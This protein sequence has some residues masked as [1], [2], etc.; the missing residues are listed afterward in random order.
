VS[1][2][3][4]N[5]NPLDIF[6]ASF[7]AMNDKLGR[8]EETQAECEQIVTLLGLA[9]GAKI[10]DAGCGFGRTVGAF[11]QLGFDATGVDISP[12]VI[13]EARRRNPDGTY[14]VHDLTRPLPEGVGPFDAVV[15]VYSSF[16]YGQ[17]I[18]D[19][20]AVLETWHAALRPGGK[21]VMELSDV[22]RSV[23]RLG[24]MGTVVERED[25]GV[26]ERLVLDPD[27]RILHVRYTAEG[28]SV[29]V[30][31]RYFEAQQLQEMVQRAGF[32]DV[33][34]YGGFDG[35]PKQPEDRL[36]LAATA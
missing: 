31:T 22:E 13:D 4:D 21:L 15:N 23:A 6:G 10:L 34:R 14:L 9:P 12:A 18:E 26:H 36:I 32:R 35:H 20:Q 7:I 25:N 3:V 1:R 16:G 24:P 27:T 5:L 28:R 11:A 33:A 17:T 2:D 29:D 8:Y 19:D 30:D